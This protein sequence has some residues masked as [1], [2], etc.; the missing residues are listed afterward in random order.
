MYIDPQ[1]WS[2]TEVYRLMT[3]LVVPRPIAWVG[4]RSRAGVDNLAPFSYF[5]AVSSRPA[6]LALSIARVR[7]SP[8]GPLQ[9]KDSARN[10]LDTGVLTVSLVSRALGPD[11]VDT[12]LSWPS[13]RSEFD[14]C[15]LTAVS[16]DRVAAPFP[17]E[18]AVAMECQLAHTI[19]MG[20]THLFVVEVLCFH[21]DDALVPADRAD[22]RLFAVDPRALD[23]LA[24]LGGASYTALGDLFALK[25]RRTP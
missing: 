17:G 12:S 9:L 3:S 16:G 1:D 11:M 18:A 24:R 7:R 20:S 4:S 21:V 8:E 22:D 15:G 14:A 23:P 2:G 10:V 25:P 5:M 19:D 13:D 6:A